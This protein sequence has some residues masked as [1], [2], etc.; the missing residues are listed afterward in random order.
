MTRRHRTWL[1]LLGAAALL[2]VGLDH[3]D[4][5]TVGHYSAIPTIGTLFA[6]NFAAAAL[7]ACAL[8][9]PWR[10]LRGETGR[11][12]LAAAG[13]AIAAGSLAALLVSESTTLFG[14]RETGYRA[15]IVL[16]LALDVAAIALLG[17]YLVA[18]RV[19]PH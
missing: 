12:V 18:Y 19:R 13:V 8:V 6:L 1:R 11:A 15:A 17:T 9:V 14:F 5:L 7:V 16:A 3:L 2:A 4:E 10:R